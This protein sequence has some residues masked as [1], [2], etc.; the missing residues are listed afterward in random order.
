MND[1]FSFLKFIFDD[2]TLPSSGTVRAKLTFLIFTHF[3]MST[4]HKIILN[5]FSIL[6]RCSSLFIG[7]FFLIV[8]LIVMVFQG[9]LLRWKN[10]FEAICSI[11][12]FQTCFVLRKTIEKKI[13]SYSKIIQ[14]TNHWIKWSILHRYT[15]YQKLAFVLPCKSYIENKH[16]SIKDMFDW[17]KEIFFWIFLVFLCRWSVIFFVNLCVDKRYMRFLKTVFATVWSSWII[18]SRFCNLFLMIIPSHPRAV[19]A[20]LTFL[21][22]THFRMSTPHKLILNNFSI[23]YRFSSLFIGLFFLIA[24]LIVMLFQGRSLRWEI[25]LNNFQYLYLSDTFCIKKNNRK[26]IIS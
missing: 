13:I 10:H 16:H 3:R 11:C 24:E 18:F 6:Y 25:I 15:K 20:K 4:P 21:I 22:F 17:N 26:K 14:C 19:R 7:L 1:F 23:L 9:C 12:I 8:E 2:Y 5:N